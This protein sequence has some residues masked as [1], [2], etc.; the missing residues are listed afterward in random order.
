[1]FLEGCAELITNSY[2]KSFF[3]SGNCAVAS[4]RA[5]NVIG[6]GDWADNR[7]IPDLFRAYF[8]N[9]ELVIRNP[10]STRPWQF[11]LEPVFGYMK[12]AQTLFEK[13]KSFSG[14]WNFGPADVKD[15]SVTDV[16]ERIKKE[17]PDLKFRMDDST[18]KPHEAK[19]LKLDI[20]KALKNLE[21]KPLLS[22]DETIQFTID[23]YLSE[24]K[25]DAVYQ[26]RVEQ[27]KKYAAK[28]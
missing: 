13:G 27:I 10:D 1:M 3:Q 25:S 23:G 9:A 22:F 20:S 12:L 14:G 19:L 2:T 11:V 16:I 28:F 26:S 7:I 18:S 8:S 6:G 21:W 5:G 24:K 4:A 17:I 15:R